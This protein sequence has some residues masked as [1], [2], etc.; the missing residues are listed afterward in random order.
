MKYITIK[1]IRQWRRFLPVGIYNV[2]PGLAK[3][4]IK[5]GFAEET[6]EEPGSPQE[7]QARYDKIAEEAAAEKKKK[8]AEKK[9]AEEKKK[10]DKA[11]GP[12]KKG[13]PGPQETGKKR[14]KGKAT[15]NKKEVPKKSKK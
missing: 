14:T 4:I 1:M 10:M 13:T 12:T 2:A 5:K 3:A 11:P 8:A 7:V 9:K 15:G 6:D